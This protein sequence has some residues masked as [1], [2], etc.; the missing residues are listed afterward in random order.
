MQTQ[1]E[2]YRL[3]PQQRRLWQLQQTERSQAYGSQC[4]V[5]L[6]GAL[7]EIN[8]K[9]ALYSLINQHEILRTTMELMPGWRWPVQAVSDTPLLSWNQVD[10]RG[11]DQQEQQERLGTLYK[12]ERRRAFDN[13]GEA[14]PR[15]LLAVLAPD[16]RVLLITLPAHCADRRS[17]DNFVRELAERY[18]DC[19]QDRK[20][21]D[22]PMQYVQFSEWQHELLEGED[23]E[24]GAEFW[25]KENLATIPALSLLF[26]SEAEPSTP[27]APQTFSLALNAE[28]VAG[29]NAVAARY[30]VTPEIFLLSCWQALL[31]RLTGQTEITVARLFDGRNYEELHE[32][33][34]LFARHLPVRSRFAEDTRLS[35]ILQQAS[36]AVRELDEWQE[37]FS[38]EAAEIEEATAMPGFLSV[39]FEFAEAARPYSSAGVTFSISQQD[40]HFE[41]SK[42]HLTCISNQNSLVTEFDYDSRLYDTNVIERVAEQYQKL[43]ASAATQPESA[44]AR[45]E[46]LTDSEKEQLLFALNDTAGDY[47]HDVCLHEMFEQQAAH[48]PDAIAVAFQD[49]ALTYRQLNER[50]NQL[51]HYLRG[52][53]VGPETMVG[54]MIERSIEMVV[55]LLGVLKAGGAYVPLDPQYPQDRLSFMME[56]SQA[57]VL[58]T[59]QHLVERLAGCAAQVVC[60]DAERE[61]IDGES[62]ENSVSGV[63]PENVAYVIYTSGST[64]KPKG[65]MIAHKGVVNYLSWAVKAYAVEDGSGAPVHSPVGFDLTVTSLLSPL[66]SGCGVKLIPEEEGVEGLSKALL[67][68][69]NFSL[70]KITP[71]HLEVLKEWLPEDELA[72]RA[73]ALIIGG[74]ALF[75]ESLSYWRTHAP[76]TRLINEYGPT[77]TVVGCCIYEVPGEGAPVGAVPIGRPIANTQLYVLDRQWQPVPFGATGE[78]YIGGDGVAR[79]YLNRPDLTAEKFVPHPFSAEAGQRLYRTGD[80]A[81]YLQDGNLEFLGRNDAQVKVRGFRIELGEIEAS[82][83]QHPDVREAV[84]VSREDGTGDA[85]LVAYVVS[86]RQ[87]IPGHEMRAHL[88]ERLPE[89]MVPSAFV[90]LDKLPLTANGKIDRHALPAPGTARPAL[91]RAYVAP[92]SMV[93]EVL[94]AVWAE[95]LG[96]ERVGINDNFFDLGGD[97][98][99]SV[100]VVALAKER[101]LNFTVQELFRSQTIAQLAREPNLT[102]G[103]AASTIKTEPFG[104][105]SQA[106]REKLPAEVED[107]YPLAMIQEAMLYHMEL[108]PD[109]PAY[110]NVNSWHLR[111]P[112]NEEALQEAVRYVVARHAVLRTGFEMTGYSHPLQLVY[113][114][115]ELPFEIFDISH[116]SFEEQTEALY[117]FHEVERKRMFDI[118]IPSLMRFFVHRRTNESFQFSFTENHAIIDGWSTTSTLAEMFDYYLAL[119]AEEPLPEEP[120]ITLEYRDFVNLEM[121]ALASEETNQYWTRA[122]GEAVPAKLPKWPYSTPTANGQNVAKLDLTIGQEML[123]GLRR[124]ARQLAVPLKTVLFAAHIKVMSIVSGLSDFTTGVTTNGRPEEIDGTRVRGNFLNTVP[125]RFNLMD[126]T[127]AEVIKGVFEAEWEMLPHRRYPL[128]AMQRNW[129]GSEPLVET[130]FAYLHFHSVEGVLRP[131]RIEMLDDNL[132]DLSETNF[133]LQTLF[134][135][136]PVLPDRLAWL[137][138]QFDSTQTAGEER[139][140]ILGYYERVLQA[141]AS[142]TSARHEAQNFLSA[143]EQEFL[144][145]EWN[146]TATE[147][148]PSQCFHEMFEAQAKRTPDAVAVRFKDDDLTYRQLNERANQLAHYLHGLGVGPETMVGVCMPR[149]AELLVGLLG[150]LKSGAA[151]VPLD[152]ANPQERLSY[153]L[154]DAGAQVLLTKQDL[155]ETLPAHGEHVLCLDK[156]WDVISAESTDNPRHRATLS[157]LA[158]VIYTS[159]STGRPKGALITHMGLSNYLT[160]CSQQYRLEDGA[161]APVHSSISFDLTITGLFA[162]LLVGR[163][164]DLLPEDVGIETIYAALQQK[165]NYSLIKITPAQLELLSRRLK[166]EQAAGCTGAFIIGGENLLAENLRFWQE[167]APETLLINEYGPTET[168]VGCSIYRVS[169]QQK[170]SGSVPIGRPISNMQ[171]YVLNDQLQPVPVGVAGELYIGGEGLARGYLKRPELTAEKF[172]PDHLGGE[173]GKR[174]YRTG[175]LARYQ[176]DGNLEF[177]GRIDQQVKIRGYRVETGEVEA[178]LEQY[179]MIR[180]AFVMAFEAEPGD[181]HLVAYLVAAEGTSVAFGE[182]REFVGAKLPDY[183]IPSAVVWL[184]ELPLTASGKI[185]RR[186][187]PAPTMTREATGKAYVAPQ[188][189]AE[190]LIVTTWQE[191]LEIE[192]VGVHDNFFDLGGDSFRVYE[193]HLKLRERLSSSLSILDLFK[194]PTVETLA[195]HVSRETSEESSFEQT[196]ER[197]QK[198]REA[199]GRRRGPARGGKSNGNG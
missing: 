21:S 124:T 73:N 133:G 108:T 3:S 175:D 191:V 185:D 76:E 112:Y 20:P 177:L 66:V 87:G 15:F 174:L 197:A 64:G 190:R 135:I 83:S 30:D 181:T 90:M 79:G 113:R 59:Q 120:P 39:G 158:Y 118:R 182:L 94:A 57:R 142:D 171:L 28:V 110:L 50:A 72:G 26:E 75:A 65:V 4:A 89:H 82:L 6:D 138:L 97:S 88:K 114:E 196:Q 130:A 29:V 125:F 117:E 8:L 44:V 46:L 7:V 157:N 69:S 152:P 183:M 42:L 136:S 146:D 194:Y 168:V 193:V 10:L 36:E 85:R 145:V 159:G 93:E 131:G 45:L 173:P 119:V 74:E 86:Q 143:E 40:I 163:R 53:G 68:G 154:E 156:D 126:G 198:R 153:I 49:E 104:L 141:I 132:I 116:L 5:V 100:R 105:I 166:P 188:T 107:A 170:L 195:T 187:L 51:A 137:Q 179:P 127:W 165:S 84:V 176:P 162:P 54:L 48:T 184:D 160:W 147:R 128:G 151:Y 81:R 31:W 169:S 19:R 60:I 47:P 32:T 167:H 62:V 102:E 41:P 91:E 33:L 139:E 18:A 122:L 11:L 14:Q 25:R 199:A 149:C 77:E 35:E 95:V 71:S 63:R 123:D 13:G 34:G 38:F 17:L 12:E 115:A 164:V 43:L 109:S 98:I 111:A 9:E 24:A 67:E 192:Q 52:Q 61:Q 37:Y 92:N 189:D 161:G 99:R 180:E 178:I 2:S 22:E 186:A 1:I 58:L 101:G 103:E 106:D 96:I 172:I 148:L 27:Y 23:A 144:L 16:K 70:V 150:V 134:I 155:I 129:G 80:L 56:D 121:Q 140:A 78:L 55:G